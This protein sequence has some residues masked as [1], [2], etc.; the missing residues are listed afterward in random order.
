MEN[1]I[2]KLSELKTGMRVILRNGSEYVVMKDCHMYFSD[3]DAL[4]NITKIGS[5]LDI[6]EDYYEDMTCADGCTEFDIMEV[7]EF[8][9]CGLTIHNLIKNINNGKYACIYKRHQPKKMTKAEI[10]AILGYEVDIV[11]GE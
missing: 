7:Y 2:T 3:I 6:N 8:S 9:F 11:E 10:E 5:W 4:V 1:K